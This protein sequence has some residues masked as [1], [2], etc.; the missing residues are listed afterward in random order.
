MVDLINDIDSFFGVENAIYAKRISDDFIN[1]PSL[2][3][4]LEDN[5]GINDINAYMDIRD[6]IESEL[7]KKLMI[8]KIFDYSYTTFSHE[9]ILEPNYK[10][11]ESFFLR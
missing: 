8:N 9:F 6:R 7:L 2:N 3:Q 1:S 4:E 5:K 10:Y 11:L